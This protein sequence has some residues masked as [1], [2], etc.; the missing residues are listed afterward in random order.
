MER[1]VFKTKEEAARAAGE[2]V[3]ELLRAGAPRDILLLLSAGSCLDIL[4][5]V[6][7]DAVLSPARAAHL[8]HLTIGMLDERYSEDPAVNNFAQFTKTD[9]FARA[10]EAG[11]DFL[12]TTVRRGESLEAYAARFDGMLKEWDKAHPDGVT[13]ATVGMGPD[14]HVSGIMP[15][16]E[17]PARFTKLFELPDRWVVGYDAEGKSPHRLR[18]TT[19]ML[20]LHGHIDAGVAYAVGE[21]KRAAFAAVAAREGSLAETPARVLR[22]MREMTIFTDI[23]I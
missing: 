17:D 4:P 2:R 1:K 18:A 19:T 21:G 6:F 3:G 23:R 16:P 15:F 8:A 22:A 11:A 10:K 5:Y 20:F 9:F 7:A 12:D 13:L 14:G